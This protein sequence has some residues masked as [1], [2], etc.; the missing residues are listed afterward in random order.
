MA[1]HMTNSPELFARLL[2]DLFNKALSGLPEAVNLMRL[3]GQQRRSCELNINDGMMTQSAS[4]G[5]GSASFHGAGVILKN[6]SLGYGGRAGRI[7]V[8][9]Y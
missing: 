3:G 6:D 4:Q 9:R 8:R 5:Q 2:L 7:K 1:Q